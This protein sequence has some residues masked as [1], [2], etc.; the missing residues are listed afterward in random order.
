LKVKAR[1]TRE[2]YVQDKATLT[3][4]GGSLYREQFLSHPPSA[5]P[6]KT[7]RSVDSSDCSRGRVQVREDDAEFMGFEREEI[8]DFGPIESIQRKANVRKL[9]NGTP[10]FK[11]TK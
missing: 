5:S 2:A 7:P 3:L 10:A 1:Y 11:Q 9:R 8:L 4:A 6:D